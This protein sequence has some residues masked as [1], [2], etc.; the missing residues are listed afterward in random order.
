[1]LPAPAQKTDAPPA[2]AVSELSCGYA[3]T[4]VLKR[5]SFTVQKGEFTAILGPN[6][7]GKS[8]LVLALSGVIPLKGGTIEILGRELGRLSPKER[9][10]R[11]AV[12]NQDSELRFPFSCREVV[13][14][15]RYPHRKRW[16][17]E[18]PGDGEA[19]DR[20]LTLTD[21]REI[22]DRLISEV[23]GGERQRALMA[24]SLA[25]ETPILLL[26]EAVSGMDV[27]RKLQLFGVLD[28]LNRTENLTVLA[29]LHDINLAALFCRRMIFLKEGAIV[30]DGET[31]EA[32]TPNILEE[33]YR[34]RV[35]VQKIESIPG[36]KQ[37]VFLP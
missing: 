16:Q 34:T 2:L 13:A 33:V 19:V 25:Q 31:D 18:A 17:M 11:I 20:A 8:T 22:A 4:E 30:A 5:I 26:D 23:S 29:V 10:R 27:H 24:K 1:L 9:A 35:M 6:G 28:E 14:M 3:G 32:L 15:A 21:T 12:L 7:A 36:K 37:V